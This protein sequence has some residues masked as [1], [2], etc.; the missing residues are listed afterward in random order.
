MKEIE[1]LNQYIKKL[2][3]QEKRLHF[4]STLFLLVCMMCANFMFS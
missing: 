3:Q 4:T 2:E 1:S